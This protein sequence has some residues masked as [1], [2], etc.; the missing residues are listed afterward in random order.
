MN[1]KIQLRLYTKEYSWLCFR[2]A[3]QEAM[4]GAM[5]E[6]EIDDYNDYYMGPTYCQLCSKE[7]VR[8][9]S[10]NARRV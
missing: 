4:K 8:E 10:K 7:E 6:S 9:R 3:T 5:V 1:I 2:H